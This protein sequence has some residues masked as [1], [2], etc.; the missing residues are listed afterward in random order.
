MSEQTDTEEALYTYAMELFFKTGHAA[1]SE[2]EFIDHTPQQFVYFDNKSDISLSQEQRNL[3]RTFNNVSRLFSANGCVFFSIDLFVSNTVRSQ[4]A[5]DIHMMIHPVVGASGTICLFRLNNE[6]M[7]SLVGFG[8][9]CILS[10]W[11]PMADGNESLI[12]K[13]DI[14]NMSTNQNSDYFLD[15]VYMLARPYYLSGQPSI[16][17][18]LPLNF[19]SGTG[20]D[21]IDREEINQ[22][23]QDRINAPLREYGDDYVEYSEPAAVQS[24]NI[25]SELDLML[26]EM[27]NK[28]DNP[29]GEELEP[30]EDL[31]DNESTELNEY[32]FNGV[33]PEIFRDPLLMVKWL[34]KDQQT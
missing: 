4:M 12:E 27:D 31:D 25:D 7:L 23:V 33:D 32:E 34:E 8:L 22:Y 9:R 15:M 13:I 2:P 5:H 16:Y 18:L 20:L 17:E 11:Y 21:D 3:F 26:L 19:I 28:D 29:F 1:T 30:E 10:D 24:I 6:V 14:S